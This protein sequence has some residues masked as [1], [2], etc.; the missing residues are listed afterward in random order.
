MLFIACDLAYEGTAD[1]SSRGLER[2][3]CSE[4][5]RA[6]VIEEPEQLPGPIEP[7]SRKEGPKQ[8][9]RKRMET[10]SVYVGIDVSKETLD[11]ESYPHPPASVDRDAYGREKPS[12]LC[13]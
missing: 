8:R 7:A 4:G 3:W 10:E 11:I 1:R 13:S 6:Q 2:P 12:A 9:R 5:R